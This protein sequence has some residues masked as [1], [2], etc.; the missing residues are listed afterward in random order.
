MHRGGPQIPPTHAPPQHFAPPVVQEVPSARHP[1]EHRPF[2]S[3][4]KSSQQSASLLQE[5]AKSR[6]E[7]C[8]RAHDPEQ[9]SPFWLQLKRLPAQ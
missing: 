7:H 2:M 9:Q 3:H 1:N 8:P 6:Q 5:E 4:A